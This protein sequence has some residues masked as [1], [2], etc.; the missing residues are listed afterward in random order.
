MKFIKIFIIASEFFLFLMIVLS[1]I[2]E[3]GNTKLVDAKLIAVQTQWNWDDYV[4]QYNNV[5][6]TF[7][8]HDLSLTTFGKPEV[9]KYYKIVFNTKRNK[10][11]PSN[12]LSS[13]KQVVVISIIGGVLVLV[14]AYL[15]YGRKK[16]VIKE[17]GQA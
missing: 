2:S 12:I 4:L 9:N 17:E 14:T 15:F 11:T 13:Y 1:Q 8:Q 3:I 16:K 7:S 5:N 10:L 6:Y